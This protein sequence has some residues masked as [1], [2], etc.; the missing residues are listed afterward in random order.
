MADRSKRG[1]GGRFAGSWPS[2][3]RVLAAVFAA[4]MLVGVPSAAVLPAL[5]ATTVA[6][7][8]ARYRKQV[9]AVVAWLQ[10]EPKT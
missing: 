9:A 4:L 1:S 6:Y 7:G 10:L 3:G 8:W 2:L 5:G